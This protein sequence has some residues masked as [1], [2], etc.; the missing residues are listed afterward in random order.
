[1]QTYETDEGRREDR[2]VQCP[3]FLCPVSFS[4]YLAPRH[5]CE[6]PALPRSSGIRT[7]QTSSKCNLFAIK[8]PRERSHTQGGLSALHDVQQEVTLCKHKRPTTL[9]T[10]PTPASAKHLQNI[11]RSLHLNHRFCYLEAYRIP[12]NNR[13]GIK[14]YW[15]ACFLDQAF[16]NGT[17]HDANSFGL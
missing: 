3:A 13:A 2:A 7:G 16:K 4:C 1:M 17:V 12:K 11:C 15:K 14:N 9:R 5:L 10:V 6:K 8:Q